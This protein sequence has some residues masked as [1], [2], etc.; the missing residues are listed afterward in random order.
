MI[1]GYNQFPFEIL[2]VNVTL[3]D[4]LAKSL[5]IMTRLEPG[6]ETESLLRGV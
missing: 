6:V 4:V 5:H 1:S 3:E 2:A